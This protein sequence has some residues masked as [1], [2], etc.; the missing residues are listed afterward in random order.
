MRGEKFIALR[1]L[2]S[3]QYY[4]ERWDE[5]RAAYQRLALSN[6]SSVM[7]RAAL[8]ALAARRGDRPEAEQ[9]DRWLAAH[10]GTGGIET[11]ARARIA[12]LLGQR[13]RAVT[14]LRQAFDKGQ[15]RV[16]VHFD[17]DFESLRGFAPFDDLLRPTG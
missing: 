11:L 4:T 10:A 12:A 1:G 17:P 15:G 16:F 9:M 7:A 13:E 8:G 6:S 5:A 3:V 2:F 14:L